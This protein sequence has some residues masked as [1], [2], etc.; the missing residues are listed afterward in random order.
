MVFY[1]KLYAIVFSKHS[2]NC[3]QSYVANKSLN[4]GKKSQPAHASSGVPQES[5]LGPPLF[6]IYINDMQQAVKYNLFF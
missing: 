2:V 4:L 3:F 5:I 6:L 1:K